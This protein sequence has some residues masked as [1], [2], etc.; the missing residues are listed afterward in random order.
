MVQ[1][2]LWA[3]HPLQDTYRSMISRCY[4]KKNKAF[5]DYGGR[6]I[7]VCDRWLINRKNGG[8]T[9]E[10]F[11][12][13]VKDMGPKPA[14]NYTLDRIDNNMDYEPSNCRWATRQQQALNRR[15]YTIEKLRGEKHHQNKLTEKQVL[16]IKKALRTPKRGLITELAKKYN[17]NRKNIYCIKNGQSWAWLKIIP[18]IHDHLQEQNPNP[19]G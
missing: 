8:K 9:S 17:V 6:G 16:E 13:F 2:R 3:D 7:K 12:N 19:H 10:G 14:K 18:R 11:Q 4:H 5:K 15:N 1:T